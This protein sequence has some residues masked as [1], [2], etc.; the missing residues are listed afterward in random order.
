MCLLIGFPDSEWWTEWR[1]RVSVLGAAKWG[2]IPG[3]QWHL[4]RCKNAVIAL[5]YGAGFAFRGDIKRG[6]EGLTTSRGRKEKEG[7]RN[8]AQGRIVENPSDRLSHNASKGFDS[9][10]SLSISAKRGL[11]DAILHSAFLFF[12]L[13]YFHLTP[14]ATALSTATCFQC[15]SCEWN[16]NDLKQGLVVSQQLSKYLQFKK[17]P[18]VPSDVRTELSVND[19]WWNHWAVR[20]EDVYVRLVAPQCSTN[21]P[22][23]LVP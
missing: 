17:R 22:R 19:S 3:T 16:R 8:D 9:I 20:Y 23:V 21:G 12:P 13:F 11:A 18:N 1:C 15:L 7:E 2:R 10:P 5:F 14:L 6:I 4:L